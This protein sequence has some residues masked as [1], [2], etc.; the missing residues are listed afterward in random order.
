M[1]FGNATTFP[2]VASLR[3]KLQ[4]ICFTHRQTPFMYNNLAFVNV[5]LCETTLPPQSF[6]C[7]NIELPMQ[8]A[9]AKLH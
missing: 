8:R 4:K 9:P 6:E 7:G 5:A 3:Q 2:L 1:F